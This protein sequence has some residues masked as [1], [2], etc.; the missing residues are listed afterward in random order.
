MEAALAVLRRRYPDA[1]RRQDLIRLAYWSPGRFNLAGAAL[2][3]HVSRETAGNWSRAFLE[4][5]D[6]F[7]GQ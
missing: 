7:L 2:R 6:A 4:L 5:V 1:Q 3:L